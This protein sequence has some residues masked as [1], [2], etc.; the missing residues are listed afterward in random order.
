MTTPRM[1][2]LVVGATGS[3]G[4]LVV[5]ETLRQGHG[6]ACPGAQRRQGERTAPRSIGGPR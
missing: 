5:N 4:R 3:I 1:T 2:V 6:R